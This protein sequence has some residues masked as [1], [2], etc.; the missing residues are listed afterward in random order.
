GGGDARRRPDVHHLWIGSGI[1]SEIGSRRCPTAV[2]LRRPLMTP[3]HRP[4]G[5]SATRSLTGEPPHRALPTPPSSSP[6]NPRHRRGYP[7]YALGAL[8]QPCT[9]IARQASRHRQS[10]RPLG[11]RENP[12]LVHLCRVAARRLPHMFSRTPPPPRK[13]LPRWYKIKYGV[14]IQG[15]GERRRRL[16]PDA[17]CPPGNASSARPPDAPAAPPRLTPPY[18]R[19][20]KRDFYVFAPLHPHS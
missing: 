6:D 14:G 4:I 20:P 11:R 5:Q 9:Q 10:R 13:G 16:S 1:G 19:G 12:E 7:C 15:Q 3:R 18:P 17:C 8:W 2:L